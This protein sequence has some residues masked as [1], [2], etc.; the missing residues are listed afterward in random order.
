MRRIGPAAQHLGQL[1]A[2]VHR[3]ADAGVHPLAAGRAVDVPGIAGEEGTALAE[4]GGDPV[5]DVV[6]GEPVH[7][8]DA[9]AEQRLGIGAELLE[10]EAGT[11]A[12]RRGDDA[13]QPVHAAAAHRQHQREALRGEVDREVGLEGAGEPDIGDV[14]ELA[15]G[16]AGE[17]EAERLPHPAMRAVAAAEI[18]GGAFRLGAGV[19]ER[20]ADAVRRPRRSRAS[21]VFHSTAMPAGCRRSTRKRSW[22]SCG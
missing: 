8:L 20:G 3:V 10:A 9:H 14:E 12:E 19:A 22:S 7:L 11:V 2:E 6:G 5:V 17:A 15:I 21:S 16:A 13:D 18:G 4:G 1:P